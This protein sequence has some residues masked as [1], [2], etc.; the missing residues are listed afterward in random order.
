MRV[1][2][3]FY[4]VKKNKDGKKMI[5]AHKHGDGSKK[6]AVMTEDVKKNSNGNGN[7]KGSNGGNDKGG[8]EEKKDGRGSG[9]MVCLLCVAT[10]MY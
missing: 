6:G 4:N 9:E 2:R 8:G 5:V 1:Y 3:E 10:Y 7:N